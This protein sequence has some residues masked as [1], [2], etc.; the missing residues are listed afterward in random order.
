M[1]VHDAYLGGAG[2]LTAALLGLFPVLALRDRDDLARG[3]LMRWLAEAVWYPTALLPGAGVTW[4]PVDDHRAEAR[5]VD[6]ALQA[7][8]RF[9]FGGDGLVASVRADSR[10]RRVAGRSELTP[11][12]GRFRDYAWRDGVRIP[13]EGEVAWL[14]PGGEE[15]Y[16]RG[17][18]TAIEPDDSLPAG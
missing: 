6:G 1:R 4:R 5:V 14:G 12:E 8:L 10:P 13:L 3:E 15:P 17:R 11:W 7:R 9:T 16:W 2:V 18:L